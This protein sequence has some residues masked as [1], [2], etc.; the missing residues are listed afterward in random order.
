MTNPK[1]STIKL[2]VLRIKTGSTSEAKQVLLPEEQLVLYRKHWNRT[3]QKESEVPTE[4]SAE[5]RW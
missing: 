3:K 2:H 4:D 1:F 5:L